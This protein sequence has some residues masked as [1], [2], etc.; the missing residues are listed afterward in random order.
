MDRGRGWTEEGERAEE[1]Q[2]SR[3]GKSSVCTEH[4]LCAH[5]NPNHF[6]RLVLVLAPFH[7]GRNRKIKVLVQSH[8]ASK[9]KP[10]IQTQLS[11]S[12]SQL[13]SQTDFQQQQIQEGQVREYMAVSPW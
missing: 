10:G 9:L 1:E 8:T 4:Q 12:K 2:L 3:R 11:S 5:L 7:R 6:I 13:L